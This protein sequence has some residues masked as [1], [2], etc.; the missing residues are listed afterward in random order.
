M[1]VHQHGAAMP[2][3]DASWLGRLRDAVHREQIR[4][5]VDAQLEQCR[6]PAH[7]DEALPDREPEILHVRS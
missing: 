5:I 6:G 1:C 4:K 7:R 2:N 3:H